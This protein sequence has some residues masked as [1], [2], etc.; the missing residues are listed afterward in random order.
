MRIW[1]DGRSEVFLGFYGHSLGGR[2]RFG[3]HAFELTA[4]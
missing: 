1:I 4:Q 3:A 2:A